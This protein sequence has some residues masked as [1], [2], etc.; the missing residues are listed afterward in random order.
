MG[1]GF[2]ISVNDVLRV[3]NTLDGLLVDF[4]GS[5]QD[6]SRV[7]I[8]GGSFGQIGSAAASSSRA[9][10]DQLV[11]TLQ[12]LT[13]ALKQLSQRVKT[14]ADGY[15]NHDAVIAA[16]LAQITAAEQATFNRH[17]NA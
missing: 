12:A 15:V 9:A 11:T 2:E 4:D 8:P 1:S 10:Q 13:S 17:R 16:L 6:V 5:T 14:S 7:T 3:A